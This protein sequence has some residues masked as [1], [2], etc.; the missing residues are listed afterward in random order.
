MANK[1]AVAAT[2]ALTKSN[3]VAVQET[4]AQCPEDI[5]NCLK[6]LG[7]R[8]VAQKCRDPRHSNRQRGG[9]TAIYADD[10]V[11]ATSTPPS[12]SEIGKVLAELKTVDVCYAELL[13]AGTKTHVFNFYT[14]DWSSSSE[15]EL[16]LQ[17]AAKEQEAQ[18][19]MILGDFNAFH[20]LWSVEKSP[21]PAAKSRRGEI[22]IEAMARHG[23]L[24]LNAKTSTTVH[25]ST[26]DLAIASAG[27]LATKEI[28]S[29]VVDFAIRVHRPVLT[30]IGGE[31]RV[32]QM[33]YINIYKN[34]DPV[35]MGAELDALLPDA[36][37]RKTEDLLT[38]LISATLAAS[39]KDDNVPRVQLDPAKSQAKLKDTSWLSDT[40]L[41]AIEAGDGDAATRCVE[42]ANKKFR[43][44]IAGVNQNPSGLYAKIRLCD[45]KLEKKRPGNDF[46]SDP[47][48]LVAELTREFAHDYRHEETEADQAVKADNLRK[49][50]EGIAILERKGVA[51][52]VQT[53]EILQQVRRIDRHSRGGIDGIE[54]QQAEWTQHSPRAIEIL[55]KIANNMVNGDGYVPKLWRKCIIRPVLKPDLV[56]YRP[57]ALL[58]F[59]EK[60]LQGVVI[61]RMSQ[62]IFPSLCSAQ[63]GFLARHCADLNLTLIADRVVRATKSALV[64][65]DFAKA[66]DVV[67]RHLLVAKLIKTGM[68]ARLI[69]YVSNYLAGRSITVEVRNFWETVRSEQPTENPYGIV[70]GSRLGPLL[71]LLFIDDLLVELENAG[72]CPSA[73]ADD[74]VCAI[75]GE[76]DDEIQHRANSAFK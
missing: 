74:L 75:H 44:S 48:K 24:P 37:P 70:Q 10:S 6:S 33:Q 71:F 47:G 56:S 23:L 73:Y 39:K 3:V 49:I 58:A 57:I 5:D 25:N 72:H 61:N 22:L 63:A 26:L 36:L 18:D 62:C 51:D 17:V 69:R 12:G 13:L 59:F 9:G 42:D 50:R 43:E 28:E 2:V 60:F 45:P 54:A 30:S 21:Q 27:M 53:T 15:L 55:R 19:T 14:P 65:I 1:A 41:A 29:H 7:L 52:E 76:T 31:R 66:F 38:L 32:P 4:W 35:A 40:T 20:E 67:P 8:L 16:A 11:L 64:C 68:D 46:N 34:V